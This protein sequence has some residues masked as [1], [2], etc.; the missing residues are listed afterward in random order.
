MSVPQRQ[1]GICVAVRAPTVDET[2]DDIVVV[3]FVVGSGAAAQIVDDKGS[4]E[5]VDCMMIAKQ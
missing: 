4:A 5:F 2:E 1:H 3:S